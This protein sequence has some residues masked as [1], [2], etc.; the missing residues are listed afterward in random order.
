[1][2]RGAKVEQREVKKRKQAAALGKTVELPRGISSD[3]TC[4]CPVTGLKANFAY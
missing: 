4:A 1:M 3:R 2:C